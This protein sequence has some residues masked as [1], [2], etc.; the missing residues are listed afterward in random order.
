MRNDEWPSGLNTISVGLHQLRE[1]GV[2]KQN[3]TLCARLRAPS[4]LCLGSSE[5]IHPQTQDDALVQAAIAIKIKLMEKEHWAA[6]HRC[7]PLPTS[8]AD[9]GG[10]YEA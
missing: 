4:W 1:H 10:T 8:G 2:N 5:S 3:E 7:A 9:V 6:S